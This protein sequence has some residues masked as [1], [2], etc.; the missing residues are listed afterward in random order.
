MDAAIHD[1]RH[2]RV[3]QCAGMFSDR[4]DPRH[5]AHGRGPSHGPGRSVWVPVLRRTADLLP[6]TLSFVLTYIQP[7]RLALASIGYDAW[8]P[9]TGRLRP[10]YNGSGKG[11]G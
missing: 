10:A 9:D 7:I 6:R 3:P 11:G 4:R 8:R 2:A 5:R 1:V